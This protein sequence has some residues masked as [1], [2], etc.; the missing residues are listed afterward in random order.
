[1]CF[2]ADN[3]NFA[4][5]WNQLFSFHWQMLPTFSSDSKLSMLVLKKE[6]AGSPIAMCPYR[7][8][9]YRNSGQSRVRHCVSYK[10]QLF[11]PHF[12]RL[13]ILM[14]FPYTNIRRD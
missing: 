12:N 1:M 8:S 13:H 9:G 14:G 4:F 2:F 5:S 6:E 10:I 3:F 7:N 11:L